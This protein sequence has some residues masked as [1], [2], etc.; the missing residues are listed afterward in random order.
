MKGKRRWHEE[1]IK[2]RNMVVHEFDDVE[3]ILVT[4]NAVIEKHRKQQIIFL[5]KVSLLEAILISL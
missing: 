1:E 5:S 3:G 4:H 2:G